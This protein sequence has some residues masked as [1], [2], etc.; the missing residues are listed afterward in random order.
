[1]RVSKT[2]DLSEYFLS[3]CHEYIAKLKIVRDSSDENAIHDLRVAT[4]R[5]TA[6]VRT[7]EEIFPEK[8]TRLFIKKTRRLMKCMGD[9][10]DS[11]LKLAE[12]EKMRKV[13]RQLA[14]LL[15]D[16]QKEKK[17]SEK[18]LIKMAERYK[19]SVMR[20]LL[21]NMGGQ[22]DDYGMHHE[23][24]WI[25]LKSKLEHR[26]ERLY[27][28]FVQKSKQLEPV[29]PDSLHALRIQAKKTRYLLEMWPVVYGIEPVALDALKK[30]QTTL[31]DVQDCSTLIADMDDFLKRKWMHKESIGPIRN[32]LQQ[33]MLKMCWQV[34]D[35][36]ASLLSELEKD[37]LRLRDFDE[38]L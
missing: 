34:P 8:E 20:K 29:S 15:E 3:V 9:V 6:M 18:T 25:S 2:A 31:G 26:I 12:V 14:P 21:F 33:K 28:E 27:G 10:R 30:M 17:R 4:R 22:I 16:L 7:C 5:L 1:M 36:L 35:E 37:L 23:K 19:L 38:R 11:Q 13:F 24:G 32:E